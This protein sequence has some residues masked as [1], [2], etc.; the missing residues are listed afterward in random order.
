M[1]IAPHPARTT[2]QQVTVMFDLESP[3]HKTACAAVAGALVRHRLAG[4]AYGPDDRGT[5]L[6]SWNVTSGAPLRQTTR[7]RPRSRRESRR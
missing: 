7:R 3:D 5:V 1:S 4:T 6:T 2:R